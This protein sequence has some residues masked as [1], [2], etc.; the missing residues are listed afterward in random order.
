VRPVLQRQ[1][2]H[3]RLESIVGERESLGHTGWR[4]TRDY[5]PEV[6][7]LVAGRP[8]LTEQA[9]AIG[10]RTEPVL[11][12]WDCADGF[13][14]AYWR[15]P[16]HTWT[17]MFVA[18]YRCGPGSG[19]T[20]SSGQCG[21]SVMTLSQAGGPNATAPSSLSMQRSLAFACS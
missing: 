1:D 2:R 20:S 12:P 4:P 8:S 14:E 16:E 10:A 11:I 9:R 19:R 5:L 15:R 17:I 3:G 21:A 6:A 18:E 7:D 13:F